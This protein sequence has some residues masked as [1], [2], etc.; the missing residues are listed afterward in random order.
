MKRTILVIFVTLTLLVSFPISV[1]GM[2]GEN[3]TFNTMAVPNG[4][5]ITIL[6]YEDDVV[7]V[8]IPELNYTDI[9]DKPN[10]DITALKY[11]QNEKSVTLTL[12]VKGLIENKGNLDDFFNMSTGKNPENF[13]LNIVL[14]GI[15]LHTSKEYYRIYYVNNEINITCLTQHNTYIE[16]T[17]FS[18]KGSVLHITFNLLNESEKYN[19]M[20]GV[21]ADFNITSFLGCYYYD[22]T[23]SFANPIE[24]KNTIWDSENWVNVITAQRDEIVRFKI[25]ITY[26]DTDGPGIGE[27]IKYITVRDELPEGLTYAFNATLDETNVSTD[28][29]TITWDLTDV[30]LF[31]NESYVI[32]F[33]AICSEVGS[34]INTVNV[35]ALEKC[36]SKIRYKEAIAIVV[37]T[38]DYRSR[39]VDS[40]GY[41]EY[42]Y[43]SNENELDGFEDYTD[44]VGDL[45]KAIVSI[46]GDDDGKI[47]HFIDVDNDG[48]PEAYWDPDDDILNP[49]I[50]VDVDYDETI[51]FVF[52]SDDD[53]V[54]DKYWD[55]DDDTIK[56]Y[57]VFGLNVTINGNGT[58]EKTP[59][60][61]MYLNNS[62]VRLQGNA[63]EGWV[64]KNWTGD[65]SGN[66]FILDVLMDS[67]KEITANFVIGTAD[68]IK[69]VVNITKP[70][71]KTLYKNDKEIR[72]LLFR[73][74]IIGP[75]TIDI[76]ASDEGSGLDKLEIYIDDVLKT[77][78][79]VTDD[80]NV[81]NWTWDE[82]FLLPRFRTI[83]VVAYDKHGNNESD[84]EKF[85][86]M[87]DFNFFRNRPKLSLL[88]AGVAGL[89]MLSKL[90]GGSG[91]DGSDGEDDGS[92]GVMVD[93]VA[94]AGGPYSGKQS[95]EIVF[96]GS[97]SYDP[98][99]DNIEYEWDFGDGSSGNAVN[100]VHSY[101]SP[102]NYTVTLTV[103][104]SHGNSDIVTTEAV[105][106]SSDVEGESEEDE[107]D[108]FWYIVSG[109]AAILLLSVAALYFRRR[110][111]V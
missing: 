108:I 42:A 68:S 94:N 3:I 95:E 47:D 84:E 54:L 105:I 56:P 98:N 65:L 36:Y 101:N 32:E 23:P 8:D 61:L 19:I 52:D 75:I 100:P 87:G 44:Y 76:N 88:L 5:T 96:D 49:L 93:P 35:T 107:D 50:P 39:D 82:Q 70:K 14:Y 99:E 71:E 38:S 63:D 26:H 110:F 102:G 1:L 85:L 62:I 12:F 74:R 24:L 89:F 46:D 21:A 10:V 9:S 33:D 57:V 55:P 90:G 20:H 4:D 31:D 67:D 58:V 27:R 80:S 59:D 104:D 40:D 73:T 106:S 48:V 41:L 30:V 15:T 16:S 51:E 11:E 43:D 22:S 79:N 72:S 64:F 7:K 45:S 111:Y 86:K 97:D 66:S 60:G 69:P 37:V 6:D 2:C 28:G 18:A 91:D 53:D 92:E 13:I 103:T 25:S 83:K 29:K 34:Q 81:F 78:I 77:T 109:L 17:S